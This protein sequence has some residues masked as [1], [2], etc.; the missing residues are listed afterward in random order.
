[1][2]N[3]LRFNWV[4][5]SLGSP[6]QGDVDKPGGRELHGGA[7]EEEAT[8]VVD[9]GGEAEAAVQ[10][11]VQGRHGS[12]GIFYSFRCLFSGETFS[13][14]SLIVFRVRPARTWC[15]CLP[16]GIDALHAMPRKY[17]LCVTMAVVSNPGLKTNFVR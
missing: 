2:K 11:P 13:D 6:A 10:A 17:S 16:V 4:T 14:F 7:R 3:T 5:I 12:A 8:G 1:M 15:F 9:D